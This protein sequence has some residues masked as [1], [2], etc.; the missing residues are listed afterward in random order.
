MSS[1]NRLL[2]A[3]EFAAALN[4]KSS[5]VR[6]WIL[7]RRIVTVKVGRLV[8]IPAAEIDKIIRA[9]LRPIKPS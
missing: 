2:K 1:E 7:E 4:I 8:R 9:G 6:R 3:E 5:C